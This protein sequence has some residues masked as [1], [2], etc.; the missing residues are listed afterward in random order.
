MVGIAARFDLGRYHATAW[1]AHVNE[2]TVEW[3]PSPWRVLRALDAAGFTDM[4]AEPMRVDLD[5]ALTRLATAPP[6]RYVLPDVEAGH[7]RHY[8][9]LATHSPSRQGDTSLLIDA[10]HVF[11]PATELQVWWD[12][13]PDAAEIDALSVASAGVGYLGRSESVCTVRVLREP[14]PM[15]VDAYPVDRETDEDAPLEGG[16]CELLAVARGADD[17]LAV[18]RTTVTDMR[19]RRMLTPDGARRVPYA[20]RG[21]EP[22]P[23]RPPARPEFRPT[24]A[25]FRIV[26]GDRPGLTDAVAVGHYLRAALQRRFGEGNEGSASSVFSGHDSAGHR[27]DQHRH[28]HYLALP[29]TDHR[30]VDTLVVW[31]PEGFGPAEVAALAGIDSVRRRDA[32]PSRVALTALGSVAEMALTPIGGPATT[33]R[34]LTPFSLPRHPKRRAGRVVDGPADQLRRELALRGLPVPIEVREVPSNW[35]RFRRARP[36]V[37]Q[38]SAANVVG[39]EM[40]FESPVPGPLALGGLSHFG[41]GL[42]VPVES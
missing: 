33:W 11:D 17:P 3:P 35:L 42:F 26:G 7:T 28:A 32:A 15:S 39:F 14:A 38:R 22:V 4:R 30:K 36:A 6:P 34:S 31:A 41:L 1:G 37:E 25:Q 23:Y 21:R 9:P 10:F 12:A 20:V 18:L 29:G 40:S 24:V 13:D 8:M 16:R 2:A 5:R 27:R 19:R